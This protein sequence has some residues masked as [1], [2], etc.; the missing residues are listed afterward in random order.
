RGI[1]PS[2]A[3]VSNGAESSLIDA[4][5]PPS[6]DGVRLLLHS[7]GETPQIARHLRNLQAFLVPP[8]VPRDRVSKYG[9]QGREQERLGNMLRQHRRYSRIKHDKKIGIFLIHFRRFL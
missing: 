1:R 6:R 8:T 5:D 3:R 7:T 2:S 9:H 4:F